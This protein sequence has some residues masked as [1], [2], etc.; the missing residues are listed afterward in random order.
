MRSDR[1]LERALV[2]A[3]TADDNRGRDIVVLDLRELTTFFDYFVIATG[4]S[5]RQLHAI[6]E[7][8][9][10]A[11]EDGLGDRR[12]GIEGYS[13]SRWILLDYGDVVIHMFDPETREYYALE[14]LW[15]QAKRV[16]FEPRGAEASTDLAGKRSGRE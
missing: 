6:S 11:L 5:R 4:T 1:A 14:E 8:I 2:A 15:A 9:D 3:R 7:E 16:P 13:E 12:M 10:H